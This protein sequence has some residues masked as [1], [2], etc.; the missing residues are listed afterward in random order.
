MHKPEEAEQLI[1]LRS[2]SEVYPKAHSFC[3]AVLYLTFSIART[4]TNNTAKR[5]VNQPGVC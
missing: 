2:F 5:G 4:K 1:G 3:D